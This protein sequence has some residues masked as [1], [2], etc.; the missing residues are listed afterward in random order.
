MTSPE[1]GSVVELD[2]TG[3]AVGR[4][5]LAAMLGRPIKAVGIAVSP[6]GRIWVTDSDGGNVIVLAPE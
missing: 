4:W 6:D 3:E 1:A 5:D 2:A